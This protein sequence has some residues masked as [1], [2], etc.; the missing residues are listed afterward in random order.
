MAI[1]GITQPET[2]EIDDFVRLRR[3]TDDCAFALE[4]YQDEETL[5]LVDGVRIP[6]DLEKLYRMYH[7]LQGKGE[8]YF[9]E[10]RTDTASDYV[11]VGDVSFWQKDM[12]IVIGNKNFRGRG[13]GTKV[14]KAL[15]KRGQKLGFPYLE[16]DEIYDYNTGS[17]R[18]F[19]GL[20]FQTIK[21]TDKGHGY[22]LLLQEANRNDMEHLL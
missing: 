6:Y 17:Q 16:V 22:R 4:W 2:I 20:G 8:V 7:Y 1:D 3:Y 15:I 19:E 12:P 5:W 11:P 13:I 14:V 10:V 9:I 18:L 21:T